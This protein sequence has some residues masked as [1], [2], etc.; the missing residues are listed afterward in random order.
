MP[1]A[2]PTV[3]I[4]ITVISPQA[5][6]IVQNQHAF[7]IQ[8]DVSDAENTPWRGIVDLH[9]QWLAGGPFGSPSSDN[10]VPHTHAH[11]SHDH[12]VP[13]PTLL[14]TPWH[15]CSGTSDETAFW[16]CDKP[17]CHHYCV[18]SVY[19]SAKRI[20]GTDQRSR[21]QPSGAGTRLGSHSEALVGSQ[22]WPLLS[23]PFFAHPEQG[24]L[25]SK[26][27]G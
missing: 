8:T 13:A 17:N 4:P 22:C 3:L 9:H 5:P 23:R 6:S 7:T 27:S 11:A 25:I 24:F 12:P 10:A 20:V 26:A 21:L 15:R 19:H 2:V 16:R 18:L 14:P 1:Y